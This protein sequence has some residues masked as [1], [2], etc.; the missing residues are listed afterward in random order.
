MSDPAGPG[1]TSEG[2]TG[3]TPTAPKDT[4]HSED[5]SE[6]DPQPTPTPPSTP[7]E[8]AA[9]EATSP[10]DAVPEAERQVTL[11]ERIEHTENANNQLQQFTT[12]ALELRPENQDLN[13]GRQ[14]WESQHWNVKHSP[15]GLIYRKQHSLGH[16]VYSDSY[17]GP[18]YNRAGAVPNRGVARS[19]PNPHPLERMGRYTPMAIEGRFAIAVNEAYMQGKLIRVGYAALL[20]VA[21]YAAHYMSIVESVDLPEDFQ[22]HDNGTGV[23]CATKFYLPDYKLLDV[24]AAD[25][26]GYCKKYTAS[27]F[28]C[29]A[30]YPYRKSAGMYD[31][32]YYARAFHLHY[33]RKIQV[34]EL[35]G[36]YRI[37]EKTRTTTTLKSDLWGTLAH[38]KADLDDEGR[39]LLQLSTILPDDHWSQ[40]CN[41]TFHGDY[42]ISPLFQ[43]VN[44]LLTRSWMT[45]SAN[46][47][48]RYHCSEVYVKPLETAQAMFWLDKLA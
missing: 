22:K 42:I 45:S 10:G 33:R 16:H 15:A 7:T 30:F 23:S 31:V 18:E 28:S 3:Q 13:V 12:S 46:F 44:N 6:A 14:W 9:A 43:K 25:R 26:D 35:M 17:F 34:G 5:P 38:C 1:G 39:L 20:G 41:G 24:I 27:S 4:H 40:R 8:G 47:F 21:A 11:T 19:F 37:I 32:N 36:D 29:W 2:K 48:L